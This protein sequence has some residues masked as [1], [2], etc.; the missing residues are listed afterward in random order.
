MEKAELLVH[1][2]SSELLTAKRPA[3][4]FLSTA[5]LCLTIVMAS[6]VAETE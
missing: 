4:C 1:Y 5:I 6:S 2:V 3:V